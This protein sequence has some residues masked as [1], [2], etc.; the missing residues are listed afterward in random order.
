MPGTVAALAPLLRQAADSIQSSCQ[1]VIGQDPLATIRLHDILQRN[2]I[3]THGGSF[4]QALSAIDNALHDLKGKYFRVPSWRLA[5]G[6]TQASIQAYAQ[7]KGLPTSEGAMAPHLA[8]VNEAGFRGAKDI[9]A[10]WPW[11]RACGDERKPRL[12]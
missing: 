9:P 8:A 7:L 6:P 12:C 2:Q 10:V 1:V 11:R 3:I 5:G 4:Q